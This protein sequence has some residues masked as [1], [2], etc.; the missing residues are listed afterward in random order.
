MEED[1]LTSAFRRIGARLR[2]S[3]RSLTGSD[4]DAD[5]ALQEA[6]FRLWRRREDITAR[7][8]AEK[9]LTATVRNAGIDT[10]RART[11]HSDSPVPEIADDTEDATAQSELL[12]EV[13]MLMET[14]LSPDHRSILYERDQYGWDITEIAE[15]H[16]LTEANVRMILSRSRKR[17]RE[18]YLQRKKLQS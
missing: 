16:G 2:R 6:F 12:A 5:D 14:S 13:K 9:L 3:A 1:A 17:V 7:E 15:A 4:A 8:Q 11:R 18:L 10:L